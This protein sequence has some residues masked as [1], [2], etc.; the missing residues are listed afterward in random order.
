MVTT[1][2]DIQPP[3]TVPTADLELPESTETVDSDRLQKLMESI[4]FIRH[5]DPIHAVLSEDGKM[6]VIKGGG[7]ARLLAARMLNIPEVQVIPWSGSNP[8]A[9]VVGIHKD[10]FRKQ[11]TT[12]QQRA[13][14]AELVEIYRQIG[15]LAP[16]GMPGS[17]IRLCGY[18][19][20]EDVAA[21]LGYTDER[22][23]Q[24]SVQIARDVHPEIRQ[25][26]SADYPEIAGNTNR[27]LQI[28]RAGKTVASEIETA[29]RTGNERHYESLQVKLKNVQ[30]KAV[31]ALDKQIKEEQKAKE[32]ERE[33]AAVKRKAA[34]NVGGGSTR[35]TST[36]AFEV[37]EGGKSGNNNATRKATRS[38]RLQVR[39]EQWLILNERHRLFVGSYMNPEFGPS[40]PSQLDLA[41]VEYDDY[42]DLVGDERAKWNLDWMVRAC[43]AVAVVTRVDQLFR[44]AKKVDMP[45]DSTIEVRAGEEVYAL[46]IFSNFQLTDLP[47]LTVMLPSVDDI[48][49][50]IAGYLNCSSESNLL[51]PISTPRNIQSAEEAELNAWTTSIDPETASQ[52]LDE[53]CNIGFT[54]EADAES[55]EI[56]LSV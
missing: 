40:L 29:S 27:L 5:M 13:M 48:L 14:D 43:K 50:A 34:K 36:V 47:S 26:I 55:E 30:L 22:S 25:L 31:K 8:A 51:L 52:L 19:K 21:E 10:L 20:M 23:L 16:E 28:A 38:R 24:I 35:S 33:R 18:R 56:Y 44:F 42:L 41:Y 9:R 1:L 17:L 6:T 2:I 32:R 15:V 54:V 39:E 37:L 53:L 12:I 11:L 46:N 3:V 4:K 49:P 45:F 7:V